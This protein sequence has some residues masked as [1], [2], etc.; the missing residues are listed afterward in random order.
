[1]I[2]TIHTARDFRS[3]TLLALGALLGLW[4]SLAAHPNAP[5][6]DASKGAFPDSH[7]PE[8]ESINSRAWGFTKSLALG[9]T[10][11]RFFTR[12][13]IGAKQAPLHPAHLPPERFTGLSL[14]V[15]DSPM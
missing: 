12:G 4:I 10:N 3:C 11:A 6:N 8:V 1:M 5:S 13:A 15:A 7:I 14:G 2:R 9:A